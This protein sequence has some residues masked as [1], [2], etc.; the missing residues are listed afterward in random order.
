MYANIVSYFITADNFAEYTSYEYIPSLLSTGTVS[1]N[2]IIIS[3]R[4]ACRVPVAANCEC[5][6]LADKARLGL[7]TL[8]YIVMSIVR[9]CGI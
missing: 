7:M 1:I 6:K 2:V 9:Y 8:L 3:N 4:D 5:M